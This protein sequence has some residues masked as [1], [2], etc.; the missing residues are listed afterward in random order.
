VT[1]YKMVGVQE[2]RL[3]QRYRRLAAR[4]AG[5]FSRMR[6]HVVQE[7]RRFFEE[8][9]KRAFGW[10]AR[11]KVD[12]ALEELNPFVAWLAWEKR[13]EKESLKPLLLLAHE[14]KKTQDAIKARFKRGM[15][16]ARIVY[17]ALIH[18]ASTLAAQERFDEARTLLQRASSLAK[19]ARLPRDIA[20]S[21]LKWLGFA[22]R[23]STAHIDYL[24]NRVGKSI[25]VKTKSNIPYQGTLESFDGQKLGIK[26]QTGRVVYVPLEKVQEKF[27]KEFA[28]REMGEQDGRVGEAAAA[29]FRGEGDAS[30]LEGVIGDAAQSLRQAFRERDAWKRTTRI[31]WLFSGT[32]PYRLRRERGKVSIFKVDDEF[33]NALRLTE[34]ALAF[35]ETIPTEYILR[36]Q[37]CC[38]GGTAPLKVTLPM[39]ADQ[40]V[41]VV[42]PAGGNSLSFEG[43][44]AKSQNFSIRLGEWYE[45]EIRVL[46]TS[47]TVFVDGQKV[48]ETTSVSPKTTE[49]ARLR[50]RTQKEAD[51]LLRQIYFVELK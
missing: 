46:G 50:F 36:F 18:Q 45:T 40:S 22:K 6:E 5:E 25:E 39:G 11:G 42:V 31:I 7:A 2:L 21:M 17:N 14:A 41:A 51:W 13:G 26:V 16:R 8:A 37:F 48:L 34:G 1:A 29:Y 33:G 30:L 43:G 32:S 24:K 12:K 44:E 3:Q 38:R 9:K 15:M 23:F 47:V 10:E 19:E 28:R 20:A 49:S 4:F 35:T 27:L